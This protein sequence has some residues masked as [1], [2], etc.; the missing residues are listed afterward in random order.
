M[1]T[2]SFI[3]LVTKTK[4]VA[5]GRVQYNGTPSRQWSR[6]T[7]DGACWVFQGA[8]F[9]P[10]RAT[11]LEIAGQIGNLNAKFEVAL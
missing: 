5:G 11:R 2:K 3:D 7:K 6:Y 1:A 4:F 9:W 10:I 8:K